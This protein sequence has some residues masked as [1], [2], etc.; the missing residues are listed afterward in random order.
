MKASLGAGECSEESFHL[1]LSIS[2]Q[3]RL[4]EFVLCDAPTDKVTPNTDDDSRSGGRAGGV[5]ALGVNREVSILL[6]L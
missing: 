3:I 5:G 6:D 2:S 1:R 4:S